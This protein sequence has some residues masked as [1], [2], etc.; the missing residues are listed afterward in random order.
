MPNSV[1][2]FP[3]GSA[4]KESAWSARDLGLIL[5]L[6][7]FPGKGYP[8][9]YSGLEN[10]VDY[11]AWG[12]KESDSTEWLSLHFTIV[13]Q[14]FPAGS[15]GKEFTFN[16]LDAGDMG[17]IP[18]SGRSP[19]EGH[20]NPLQYSCQENPM[21]RGAWLTTD[22]GVTKSWTWL[23]RLNMHACNSILKKLYHFILPSTL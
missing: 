18:G 14:G 5:G 11:S 10:S 22:H 1:L 6:G 23:K 20:G 21:D 9:Q 15:V 19:G 2:G 8:L 13:L 3:C 4:G 17:S 16:A 12:C 7:R